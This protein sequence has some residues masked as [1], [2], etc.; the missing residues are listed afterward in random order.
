MKKFSNIKL[1]IKN[2]LISNALTAM[3]GTVAWKLKNNE[4]QNEK[5]RSSELEERFDTA[6]EQNDELRS[7]FDSLIQDL[8]KQDA[9]KNEAD[10]SKFKRQALVGTTTGLGGYTLSRLLGADNKISLGVGVSSG[11]LAALLSHP[12]YRNQ[13]KKYFN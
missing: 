10:K 7:R 5:H 8:E 12:D 9:I 3:I 13:L 6:K 4:L 1:L 11:L 2:P